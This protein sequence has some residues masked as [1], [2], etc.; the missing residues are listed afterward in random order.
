M[1]I[2]THPRRAD[3]IP[4]LAGTD[5][6]GGSILYTCSGT[7]EHNKKCGKLMFIW[8]PPVAEVVKV[9]HGRIEVK[10]RRCK[11]L[12]YILLEVDPED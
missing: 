9:D 8:M 1:T 4:Q 7:N 2:I 6:P 10:C 5:V 12:N 11:T 3:A